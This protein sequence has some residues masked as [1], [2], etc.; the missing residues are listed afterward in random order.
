[1]KIQ[2]KWVFLLKRRRRAAV[3][4]R[5]RLGLQGT[6]QREKETKKQRWS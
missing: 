6:E 4:I 1:M 3:F 5:R 2:K